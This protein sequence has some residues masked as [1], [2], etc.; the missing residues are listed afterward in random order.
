MGLEELERDGAAHPTRPQ[1]PEGLHLCGGHRGQDQ[2]RAHGAGELAEPLGG[3]MGR[4]LAAEVRYLDLDQPAPGALG[5][6]RSLH[7]AP[8]SLL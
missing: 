7:G 5:L 6:D 2:A 4:D 1:T 8:P 3:G